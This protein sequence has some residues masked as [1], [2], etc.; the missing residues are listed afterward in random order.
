MLVAELVA[1]CQRLGGLAGADPREVRAQGGLHA[2]SLLQE[3]TTRSADAELARLRSENGRLATQLAE[4]QA[5]EQQLFNR[6]HQA[7]AQARATQG[8]LD[9]SMVAEQQR[10]AQARAARQ[11]RGGSRKDLLGLSGSVP[12]HLGGS[13]APAG[14][15][16]G[17]YG[18]TKRQYCVQCGHPYAETLGGLQRTELANLRKRVAELE[19]IQDAY[20]KVEAKLK[21]ASCLPPSRAVP[22]PASSPP[23]PPAP[24]AGAR[25]A[26][27]AEDEQRRQE[28]RRA[29][30][31]GRP[32]GGAAL[33]GA[34]VALRGGDGA[35][36]G[37]ARGGAQGGGTPLP[38]PP[39]P[40]P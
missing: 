29:R 9:A 22:A 28:G 36:Q 10:E 34:R 5:A 24:P 40:P 6:M 3:L 20:D 26:R 31:Q 16:S 15:S 39:P 7:E 35:P 27:D 23:P 2:L 18:G 25:E 4:R 12:S 21:E 33:D 37:R 13:T 11:A 19:R 14:P 32:G 30:D 38:P 1:L 8:V 17:S